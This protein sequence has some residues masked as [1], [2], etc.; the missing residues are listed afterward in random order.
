MQLWPIKQFKEE[1]VWRASLAWMCGCCWPGKGEREGG[2]GDMVCART[3]LGC[4][5]DRRDGE[6]RL[7]KHTAIGFLRYLLGKEKVPT[8]DLTPKTSLTAQLPLPFLDPCCPRA[9]R[10]KKSQIP[11]NLPGSKGC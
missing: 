6:R 10:K 8:D 5:Q 4:W 9:P 7:L 1:E 11:K 2:S 3:S